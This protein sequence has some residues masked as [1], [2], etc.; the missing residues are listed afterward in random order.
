MVVLHS[1]LRHH[2]TWSVYPDR[3]LPDQLGRQADSAVVGNAGKQ[4][5]GDPGCR[6][7]FGTRE[8]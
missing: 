4:A 1:R 6:N 7:A 2:C 5:R 3:E 8:V